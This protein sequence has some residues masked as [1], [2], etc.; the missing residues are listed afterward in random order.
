MYWNTGKGTRE[1]HILS[2]RPG[3]GVRNTFTLDSKG[4]G[5]I[6]IEYVYKARDYKSHLRAMVANDR[7]AALVAMCDILRKEMSSLN[8]REIARETRGAKSIKEKI[9]GSANLQ[10]FQAA[11]GSQ[12]ERNAAIVRRGVRRLVSRLK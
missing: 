12:K 2:D 5:Q 9:I 3:E 7:Q 6:Q 8:A 4:G 10:W 11:S 1:V